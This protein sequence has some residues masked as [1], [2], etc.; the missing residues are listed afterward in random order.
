M[1]YGDGIDATLLA[2]L[3]K[4]D[5]PTICNA[6]EIAT[7]GRRATGF[8]RRTMIAPFPLLPPIIGFARTA[9]LRAASP[10]SMNPKTARELRMRYYDH[11][12]AHE[13]PPT[14]VVIQDLDDEPGIGAFWGEVHS[15]VHRALGCA[16]VVTNG[17]VRDLD[18]LAPDFPIIAGCVTPSHA[19]VRVEAIGCDVD[20]LGMQ[21]ANGDL[22]HADRHGAVRIDRQAAA[23][24]PH[25]IDVLIAREKLI[26]DAVARPGFGVD[27]IRQAMAAGDD[28]H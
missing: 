10:S 16:G 15:N 8:T 22:I 1:S 26:L 25:A 9:T 7:G 18:V 17:A 12:A 2:H 11:V 5:T 20:I 6:L 19:F 28:V 4:F 3:K 23:K 27:A 14:V 13:G 24:L 21:V